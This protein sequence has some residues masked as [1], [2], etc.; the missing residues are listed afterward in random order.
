MG[1]RGGVRNG[2][3]QEKTSK[4]TLYLH[5]GREDN[6]TVCRSHVNSLLTHTCFTV[7]SNHYIPHCTRAKDTEHAEGCCL[8]APT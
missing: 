8:T 5:S 7:N 2:L 4:P 3:T 1:T 6:I